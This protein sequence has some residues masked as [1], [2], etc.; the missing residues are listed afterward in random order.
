LGHLTFFNSDQLSLKKEKDDPK[1]AF[2]LP[3]KATLYTP[4]TT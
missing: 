4:T 2:N 1:L 3:K